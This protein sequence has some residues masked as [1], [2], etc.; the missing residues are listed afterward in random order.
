MST[1]TNA[2]ATG[3]ASNVGVGTTQG[4][5]PTKTM[6]QQDF[7]KILVA[8]VTS[9]DPLNPN[10]ETD[11]VSQMTQFSMLE[12]FKGVQTEMTGLRTG[13]D[14]TSANSLL[15]RIVEVDAGKQDRVLGLVSAVQIEAGKPKVVVGGRS[16]DVAKIIE[17]SPPVTEPAVQPLANALP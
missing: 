13:Q 6:D 11:F 12:Q 9:Q 16:F 3:V 17:V 4:R 5:V 7:L 2:S 14:L 8:Q 1:I 15:G 10:G